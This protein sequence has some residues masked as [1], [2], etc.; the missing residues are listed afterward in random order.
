MISII[1]SE[2]IQTNDTFF[3]YLHPILIYIRSGRLKIDINRVPRDLHTGDV[4]YCD[5]F[6]I[7]N[8][9]TICGDICVLHL[10]FSQFSLLMQT[11]TNVKIHCDSNSDDH[12]QRYDRLREI[13]IEYLACTANEPVK[14]CYHQITLLTFLLTEF[15]MSE[16]SDQNEDC[17]IGHSDAD[18]LSASLK[19][20]QEHFRENIRIGDIAEACHITGTYLARIYKKYLPYTP[21]EF[22]NE[23]RLQAAK[24]ML[25]DTDLSLKNITEAVG[26][27]S[28]RSFNAFFE[29]RYHVTP[30]LF[31]LHKKKTSDS[32]LLTDSGAESE[33][34]KTE[35]LPGLTEKSFSV[36]L[37]QPPTAALGDTYRL[38]RVGKLSHLGQE[39]FYNR[40]IAYQ[41]QFHFKYALITGLTDDDVLRGIST[42]DQ[43][44]WDYSAIDELMMKILDAGLIPVM[45]ISGIPSML[46]A[47]LTRFYVSSVSIPDD[48]SLITAFFEDFFTHLKNRFGNTLFQWK[49]AIWHI[50]DDNQRQEQLEK[51]YDFYSAIYK[52]I[53]RICPE[54]QIGSPER[55][56]RENTFEDIETFSQYCKAKQCIPD[57]FIV[58]TSC[59]H[60]KKSFCSDEKNETV[61]EA[62]IMQVLSLMKRYKERLQK[63]FG[64]KELICST[65]ELYGFRNPLNDTLFAAAGLSSFLTSVVT[66]FDMVAVSIL[67]VQLYDEVETEE[68]NKLPQIVTKSGI[69]KACGN[70]YQFLMKLRGD[71]ESLDQYFCISR[72]AD[73]FWLLLQNPA[74]IEYRLQTMMKP[75]I[76]INYARGFTK[77]YLSVHTDS[78]FWPKQ[79]VNSAV[80]LQIELE[81]MPAGAYALTEYHINSTH[82]SAYDYWLLEGSPETLSEDDI[83]Y[84]SSVS[85]PLC[86]KKTIYV[87]GHTLLIERNLEANEV[88]LI[89]LTKKKM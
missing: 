25:I 5:A 32:F 54:I 50:P 72:E 39:E 57:F 46:S 28:A 82:G 87:T 22:L 43:I 41:K 8:I 70:A 68:F 24:K 60:I 31:R 20:I 21:S 26:F 34:K 4:L 10:D 67:P 71:I 3:W 64:S 65:F 44:V 13:I 6:S 30:A 80:L 19:Y 76:V 83:R 36:D 73:C 88:C 37:N 35:F 79:P 17:M 7:F 47:G 51:T 62:D 85:V 42:P 81:H 77:K 14:Y 89:T 29:R 12:Q 74:N 48:I 61:C 86:T 49:C 58:H 33:V 55:R 75:Q 2:T 53:R 59:E 63:S 16:A 15:A 27:T 69:F 9:L 40:F 38:M 45:S 11:E 52:V 56:I 84:L 1:R 18:L 23:T 78:E 66:V